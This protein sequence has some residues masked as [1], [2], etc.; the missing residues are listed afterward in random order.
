MSLSSFIIFNFFGLSCYLHTL[1]Q[2]WFKCFEE[3]KS[4]YCCIQSVS[5]TLTVA[6]E[7]R[8]HSLSANVSFG[9]TFCFY[10]EKLQGCFPQVERGSGVLQET[11]LLFPCTVVLC[12]LTSPLWGRGTRLR[13]PQAPD[14]FQGRCGAFWAVLASGLGRGQGVRTRALS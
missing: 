12:E 9:K 13:D 11:P 10:N 3:V 8:I 5:T 14:L 6:C 2:T 7:K 4:Y 1:L